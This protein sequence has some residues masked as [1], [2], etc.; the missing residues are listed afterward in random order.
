[1]GSCL[2]A[3]G[4]P[5]GPFLTF[6]AQLMDG[7]TTACTAPRD[8]GCCDCSG[9]SDGEGVASSSGGGAKSLGCALQDKR[10]VSNRENSVEFG[11]C[12]TR[13]HASDMKTY[14]K[15]IGGQTAVSPALGCTRSGSRGGPRPRPLPESQR[16]RLLAVTLKQKHHNAH[17]GYHTSPASSTRRTIRLERT[18]S[19]ATSAPISIRP[20][21]IIVPIIKV[22]IGV[23]VLSVPL[24]AR[25]HVSARLAASAL[26]FATGMGLTGFCVFFFFFSTW[27]NGSA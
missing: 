4:A 25:P 26:R 10:A 22:S 8:C 18:I 12:A 11:T 24:Q 1:M 17:L 6:D 2:A 14:P 7:L 9:T 15:S 27:R 23:P 3:A 16:R 20:T 13:A 5:A 19:S 21:P